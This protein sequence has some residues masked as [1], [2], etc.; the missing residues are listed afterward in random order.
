MSLFHKELIHKSS[1]KH[2][3]TTEKRVKERN[4]YQKMTC[5]LLT[6]RETRLISNQRSL[7]IDK[8][9]TEL[10]TLQKS[11]MEIFH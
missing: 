6:N 4:K 9:K 8:T 7:N 10:F 1:R 11:K 3:Y 5:G 2:G